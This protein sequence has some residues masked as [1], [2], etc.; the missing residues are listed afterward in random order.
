M[1]CP[2]GVSVLNWCEVEDFNMSQND[3]HPEYAWCPT[4]YLRWGWALPERDEKGKPIGRVKRQLQQAWRSIPG[5]KI[6]WRAV[7]EIN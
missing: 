6:S 1:L 2:N 4:T 7:P 3:L 5:G